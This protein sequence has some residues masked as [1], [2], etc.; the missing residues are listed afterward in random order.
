MDQGK[1]VTIS[2]FYSNKCHKVLVTISDKDCIHGEAGRNF[3][4]ENEAAG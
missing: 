2:D 4:N 1:I 3:R